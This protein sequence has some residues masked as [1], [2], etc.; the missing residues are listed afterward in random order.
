M[1][2]L[3]NLAEKIEVLL[4]DLS[5]SEHKVARQVLDDIHGTIRSSI[6]NLARKSQV[7]EPTI[8]RF[9]RT[10]GCAGF[11]DFKLQLAQCLASGQQTYSSN[12]PKFNDSPKEYAR[13][14]FENSEQ[15]LGYNLK[16]IKREKIQIAV[17]SL[18]QARRIAFYGFGISAAV[19][20]DAQQRFFRLNIPVVAHID[21]MMQ[22]M[23]AAAMNEKDVMVAISHGETDTPLLTSIEIARES[24]ATVIGITAADSPMVNRCSLAIETNLPTNHNDDIIYHQM[25]SRIVQLAIIDVL[26]TGV[27][28]KKGP[29]FQNHLQNIKLALQET[30]LSLEPI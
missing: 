6:S 9:C 5:K 16:R 15:A 20:L 23:E 1:A 14:V 13:K 8:N 26:A 28:L 17:D 30:R 22:R 10:L 29:D 24:K 7:S 11:P 12:P 18:S 25:T 21:E 2:S 4:S 19:A 3:N 27:T